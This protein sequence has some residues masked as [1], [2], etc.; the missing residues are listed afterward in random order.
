M[1]SPQVQLGTLNR[2]IASV[3]W[4]NFPLLNVTPAFLNRQAIRLSFEGDATK[5]L[6]A[7]TGA[8]TSPE[9][10]QMVSL[11]IHLLKTQFLAQLYE[12]QRLLSSLL[13][14][15]VVRPDAFTLAPYDLQNC[16]IMNVRE[17]D[18]SGEDAGYAVVISGTYQINSSLWG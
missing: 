14:N 9:P 4:Q 5:F 17:L 6:P 3:T 13:G 18:F 15:G 10:Y 12:S 2:L 16:G 1:P 8:V 7:N 11:T